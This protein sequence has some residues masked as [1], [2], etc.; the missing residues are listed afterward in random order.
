M[1][2]QCKEF[3]ENFTI[4][5]SRKIKCL[6]MTFLSAS[7]NNLRRTTVF[8]I[9]C[10]ILILCNSI[11]YV[12]IIIISQTPDHGHPTEVYSVST[13]H[14]QLISTQL[15]ADAHSSITGVHMQEVSLLP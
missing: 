6:T 4:W 10:L 8:G 12:I 3:L 15:Y 14:Q 13:T 1:S 7:Y 9:H 11:N 5:R 2:L